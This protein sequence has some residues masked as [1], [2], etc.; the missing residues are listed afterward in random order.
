[1]SNDLRIGLVAEG[2]TDY[3]VIQAALKA[4]L[5][6]PF[7]L[8][9]L[10][11]ESTTPILGGGWGGVAKWCYQTNLRYSGSLDNDPLLFGFHFLIIHI[12]V[13]V[14]NCD[15]KDYGTNLVEIAQKNNW[16]SLPCAKPCP[17][18]S[19][20]AAELMLVIQSWLGQVNAGTFTVFCLPAQA[21][22]TWLATA[23]LRPNDPWLNGGECYPKPDSKLAQLPKEQRINKKTK[24]NYQ[25]HSQKLTDRWQTV[26]QY[27]PQAVQFEQFVLDAVRQLEKTS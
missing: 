5:P 22:D 1:M 25:K 11:P 7:I 27:C 16:R 20:T 13:D 6:N 21:S 24:I 15:Y 17:P 26:K 23:L 10:Q 18:A 2:P 8:T 9:Q 12:D 4:V 3:E 19:D 14:G